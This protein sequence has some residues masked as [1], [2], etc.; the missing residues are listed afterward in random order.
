MRGWGGSGIGSD[1]ELSPNFGDGLKDQAAAW[2][3]SPLRNLMPTI[4]AQPAEVADPPRWA[5]HEPDP[6]YRCDPRRHVA[7]YALLTGADE[8]ARSDASKRCA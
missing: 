8:K 7:G 1:A 4:S 3:R 6:P 5:G 2:A